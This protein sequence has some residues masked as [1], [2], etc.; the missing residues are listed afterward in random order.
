MTTP[1]LT[2]EMLVAG[3]K[4]CEPLG[5]LVDWRE[6]FG[7]EEMRKVWAAMHVA[8]PS[9]TV[10][11]RAEPATPAATQITL[12]RDW[13]N[14]ARA[15]DGV[16]HMECMQMVAC[17][18]RMLELLT[19]PAVPSAPTDAE[20][21][22]LLEAASYDGQGS[23][24]EMWLLSQIG[25]MVRNLLAARSQPA[26]QGIDER[27]AFEKHIRKDC[28]DLTTF[29]YGSNMHYRNSAVNNA[30]TGWQ[31]RA[32]L[33]Q[34][35]AAVPQWQPIETAPKNGRKLILA[36]RNRADKARTVMARWLTDEEAAETDADGV[37]LEGGWY[38]CIDNWGEYT[39]VTLNEGE[40]T[41][42]MLP[43]APPA[44]DSSHQA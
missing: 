44:A 35:P 37:G 4:E 25:D 17:G 12:L 19:L 20:L 29:G 13:W 26:A 5:E 15:V 6:G 9:L 33:A 10:G 24:R 18:D 16:K 28:G 32:A 22:R 2:E 27:A 3:L 11:E 14:R 31:A 39:E 8:A 23:D 41:H 34:A 30:W 36:Y 40:P 43:P 38:E 7:R 1:E 21:E 42:W